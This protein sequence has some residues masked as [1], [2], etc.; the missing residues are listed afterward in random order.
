MVKLASLLALAAGIAL[1]YVGYERDQS[2]AGRTDKA[3]SSLGQSIDGTP[4][5]TTQMR[6]YAGGV[7]L[8]VAGAI[9]LGLVRK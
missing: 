6:Y 8:V 5:A 7:A 3:L 4:R 2:L 9:G 1:F